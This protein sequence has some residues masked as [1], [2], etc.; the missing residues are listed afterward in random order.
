M[1]SVP[2]KLF[3]GI[4]QLLIIPAA[5]AAEEG[6]MVCPED[7]SSLKGIDTSF[8][9]PRVSW[10]QVEKSGRGYAF[11]KATEGITLTDSQFAKSWA[12]ALAAKVSRGAY[13]FYVPSDDPVKQADF[14]LERVGAIGAGDLPP[15][16]D[17][18]ESS[19]EPPGVVVSRA[20]QW[21]DR[22]E[23]KTGRVPVI[24]T[25]PWYWSSIGNPAGFDRYPLFIANYNVRCPFV[26]LPWKTWTFWQEAVGATPGVIGQA[27]LDLFNGDALGLDRLEDRGE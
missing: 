7:R 17:W 8:Y 21:L 16:L 10:D 19:H 11:I 5:L 24:Y 14:F 6:K 18:E 27:D 3:L 1:R 15:M 23:T 25:Y 12:A 20:R 9:Q 22:V 4:I 13:H 2:P 26:P